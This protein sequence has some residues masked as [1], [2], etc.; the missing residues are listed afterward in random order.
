ML[1]NYVLRQMKRTQSTVLILRLI[2]IQLGPRF[3]VSL[4]EQ[5]YGW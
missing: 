5:S 3:V 1:R 2:V 4:P